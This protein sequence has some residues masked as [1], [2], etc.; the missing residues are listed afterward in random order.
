MVD[1][2]IKELTFYSEVNY[3]NDQSLV[4]LLVRQEKTRW[5]LSNFHN[6][7]CHVNLVHNIFFN[8]FLTNS[9]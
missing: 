2:R 8:N 3:I 6:L 7:C 4:L 1:K 9:S 5:N